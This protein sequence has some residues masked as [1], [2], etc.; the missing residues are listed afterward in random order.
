[1]GRTKIKKYTIKDISEIAGVSQRTVSRVINEEEKV[2]K[3]R[4]KIKR[5]IGFNWI[6]S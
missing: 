2:R 3:T 6:S 4:D 1:M 5:I